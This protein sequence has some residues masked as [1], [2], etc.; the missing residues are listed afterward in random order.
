MAN[1]ILHGELYRAPS[2]FWCRTKEAAL[3][4]VSNWNI[5]QY[6]YELA[7]RYQPDQR[8]FSQYDVMQCASIDDLPADWRAL[9]EAC[10]EKYDIRPR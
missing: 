4:E 2:P 6:D 1:K 3:G 5:R 9:F 7:E 8:A 10:I